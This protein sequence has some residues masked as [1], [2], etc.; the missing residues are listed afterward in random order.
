VIAV[1]SDK[2]QPAFRQRGKTVKA[3]IRIRFLPRGTVPAR[4]AAAAVFGL[5]DE[6]K[7][8]LEIVR[9]RFFR[10]LDPP[11]ALFIP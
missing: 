10:S 8:Q 1:S 3:D 6:E 7:S 11:V 2:N 5:S 4:E 9:V